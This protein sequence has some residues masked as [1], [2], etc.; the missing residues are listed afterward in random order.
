MKE[1]GC[2]YENELFG[3]GNSCTWIVLL[4]GAYFFLSNGCIGNIFGE[5]D[6]SIIWIIVLFLFLFMYNGRGCGSH[7]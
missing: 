1:Y 6:N 3:C 2:G 5:C 7:C 4:V